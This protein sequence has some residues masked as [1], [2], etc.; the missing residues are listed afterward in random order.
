MRLGGYRGEFIPAEDYDLWCRLAAL[1]GRSFANLNK[2]LIRYR[3]HPGIERNGYRDRQRNHGILAGRNYLL[4]LGLSE[5]EVDMEAH[6]A[7]AGHAGAC[8]IPLDRARAWM[9]RLV[10]LNEEKL[11]CDP[12]LFA[13]LCHEQF[14]NSMIRVPWIPER[15][16]R[17]VPDPLKKTLKK[18][19]LRMK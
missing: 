1:P 4:A 18:V 13:R 14:A 11:I 17:C 9:E 15:L 8:F 3:E 19:A 7:F 6:A 2:V 10:R 5:N 16:K 12:A